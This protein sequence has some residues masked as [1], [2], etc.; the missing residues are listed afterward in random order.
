MT[1]VV[2]SP[3][4]E[5]DGISGHGRI[6]GYGTNRMNICFLINQLAPGGAPTLLLDIVRH[7]DDGD[8]DYTICFIEGED[9]LVP[10]F[11]DAGARVV[12]FGAEFKFDPRALARM[13]RFFRREEFDV[14]H[15]HLPYSQTLGRVFGKLGGQKTTISTQHDFSDNYHPITC[16]LEHS[17]R[18][19]DTATVAVSQ[20]VERDFTGNSHLFPNQGDEWCTIYNGVD[21]RRF[22]DRVR[23]AD[24]KAVRQQW[25][26]GDG[27]VFL[28]VARY[29]SSKGQTD[30]I[31]AMAHVTDTLPEATLLVVGW[32]PLEN[33]LRR[34]A[35]ELGIADAV[36]VTGRVP[37]I[38][39]YY[40]AG[41]VFVFPSTRESFGIV[42]LEAMA[43]KLPVVATDIPGPREVVGEDRTTGRLVPPNAPEQ[44]AEAMMQTVM[45]DEPYGTNGYERAATTFDIRKT[46]SSYVQ[47]YHEVAGDSR[48]NPRRPTH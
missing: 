27:P 18:P 12:D 6:G 11:E 9:T 47:L 46:A 28:N 40:A 30:L 4:F 3:H 35:R 10:D 2:G 5:A 44:L 23:Q 19:L 26:V 39:E 8:I 21:C 25:E 13:A 1:T 29:Q 41:D 42:L 33:D 32:G 22:A 31:R 45:T 20:S 16:L 36:H 37:D 14:L 43:A 38:A 15:A 17:T 7:T 48:P 24:G 34:L